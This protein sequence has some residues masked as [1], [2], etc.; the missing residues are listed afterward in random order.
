MTK[1]VKREMYCPKCNEWSTQSIYM[2]VSS[3]LMSDEEKKKVEEGTLFK[4]YCPKCGAEL[5][6]SNGE[7]KK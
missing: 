3:F 5:V 4:N 2:S 7:D 6:F 1:V